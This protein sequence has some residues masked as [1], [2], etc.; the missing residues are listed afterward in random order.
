MRVPL[1]V[2]TSQAHTLQTHLINSIYESSTATRRNDRTSA[3]HTHSVR[4]R[5]QRWNQVLLTKQRYNHW[6]HLFA[7]EKEFILMGPAR[8]S[9]HRTSQVQRG[10]NRETYVKLC[11][12]RLHHHQHHH[13]RRHHW[14]GTWNHTHTHHTRSR[15]HQCYK[16]GTPIRSGFK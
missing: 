16:G 3:T 10:R 15:T 5:I 1:F 8:T 9:P 12:L 13:H 14:H 11:C 7:S 6:N 4:Y 2:S